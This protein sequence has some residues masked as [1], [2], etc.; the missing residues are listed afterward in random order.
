[1]SA[2][3]TN[4]AKLIIAVIRMQK[5]MSMY[6]FNFFT[7]SVQFPPLGHRF[8]SNFFL[9]IAQRTRRYIIS[10]VRGSS[11]TGGASY[12]RRKPPELALFC[13]APIPEKLE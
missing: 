7:A 2:M 3:P 11:D 8:V 6:H 4:Q 10:R 5:F 12:G 1:M 9:E 13:G